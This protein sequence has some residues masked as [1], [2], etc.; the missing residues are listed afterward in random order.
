MTVCGGSSSINM[1]WE[2]TP[3]IVLW[4]DPKSSPTQKSLKS[5]IMGEEMNMRSSMS[6]SFVVSH[7]CVGV[8][9]F[10]SVRFMST[11]V[12]L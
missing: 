10:V 6:L 7:V 8:L 12:S 5:G 3:I 11:M 1:V 4:S 2:N 9:S